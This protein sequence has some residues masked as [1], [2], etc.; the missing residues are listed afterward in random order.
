MK[1]YGVKTPKSFRKMECT[2][3]YNQSPTTDISISC[4]SIDSSTFSKFMSYDDKGDSI[5][6]AMGQPLQ[7]HYF[8]TDSLISFHANCYAKGGIGKLDWNVYNRFETFPPNTV[9]FSELK[10]DKSFP[11][12]LKT[13]TR[14]EYQIVL[15]WTQLLEKQAANLVQL[16]VDHIK[17][18]NA[19]AKVELILVNT[20]DY[21]KKTSF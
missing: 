13:T 21:F 9:P 12:F 6:N 14:K 16:V 3:L 11:E 7:I 17:S 2:E 8:R 10:Q 18:N 5:C 15:F 1:I 19:Q 20:D 4:V